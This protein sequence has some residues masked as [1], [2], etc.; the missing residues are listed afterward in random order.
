MLLE[1]PTRGLDIES[2]IYLWGKLKERCNQGGAIIFTSSD[3]DELLR[4]SDRILVFFAGRVS[5]SP[6]RGHGHCRPVGTAHRRH[7]CLSEELRSR[8]RAP[9]CGSSRQRWINIGLQVGALALAFLFT[10][11]ILLAAGA[12][13]LQAYWQIFLGA[14]GSLGN[15]SDVLV[16]WVPLLLATAGVLV[17]FAAGLW[18][19]GVEGQIVLGAVLTTWV[20]RLLQDTSLSPALIIC[21]P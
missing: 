7:R 10:S 18:N 16:A 1:H 3:L 19:I 4:Y 12:P 21:W 9:V 14:F 20:L 13:P 11:I 17:T 8:A 15:L 2:V 5:G 6:G